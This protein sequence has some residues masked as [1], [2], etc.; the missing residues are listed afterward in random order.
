MGA[1]GSITLKADGEDIKHADVKP[2]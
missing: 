1:S 2:V